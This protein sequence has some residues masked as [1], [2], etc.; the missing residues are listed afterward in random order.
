LAPE[1]IEDLLALLGISYAYI[2]PV[3]IPIIIDTNPIIDNCVKKLISRLYNLL[4]N[5]NDEVKNKK[6]L[7]YYLQNEKA[8]NKTMGFWYTLIVKTIVDKYKIIPHFFNLNDFFDIVPSQSYWRRFQH[9]LDQQ[10][11]CYFSFKIKPLKPNR[12]FKSVYTLES[13]IVLSSLLPKKNKIIFYQIQQSIDYI[14]ITQFHDTPSSYKTNMTYEL[15]II[16]WLDEA[17]RDF[18]LLCEEDF[19]IETEG[20]YA[21]ENY[22]LGSKNKHQVR[23]LFLKLET[24][25]FPINHLFHR[26]GKYDM[27]DDPIF[28]EKSKIP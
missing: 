20:Y 11:N 23:N 9:N 5:D 27:G 16:A 12:S 25:L 14:L 19:Q 3:N 8:V 6:N 24:A 4:S 22:A 28:L 26:L 18:I 7:A 15:I 2:F 21:N 13:P 17:K 10:K 1:K